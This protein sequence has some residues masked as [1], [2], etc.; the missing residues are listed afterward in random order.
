M[1][2]PAGS[3]LSD[4]PEDQIGNFDLFGRYLLF[5]LGRTDKLISSQV[6]C[7]LNLEFE[8]QTKSMWCDV[9]KYLWRSEKIQN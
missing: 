3:R 2:T 8:S 6:Q 1:P 4:L 5:S 7:I 9:I